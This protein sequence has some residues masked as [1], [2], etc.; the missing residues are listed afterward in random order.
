MDDVVKYDLKKHFIKLEDHDI[1]RLKQIS[2]Y[3]WF[4]DN[5]EWQHQFKMMKDFNAKVEIQAL[6]A[7]GISFISEHYLPEK[8]KNKEFLE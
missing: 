6:S 8:I 5:K 1:S 2:E 3:E 4:K 7:R